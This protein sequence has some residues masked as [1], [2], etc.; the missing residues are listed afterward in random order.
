M[1]WDVFI[2][3]AWEDK[4]DIARPLAEALRREGLRVWYDE[5]TLTLGD[6]LRRSIDRGLAQSRYGVVILSSNFFAKEWPQ[7][8]LDGLAAREVHGE[9]VILPVWHNI[10]ADQVREYSP[11]LADRVAVLSDRGLEHVVEKLLRVIKPTELVRPIVLERVQLF[12]PEMVLIPAGEFLMGS[13]P[14]VDK[15]AWDNEQP[16]S[17]LYLLDYYLAKTPVTNAQ[18]AAFVQATDYRQ[19]KHWEDEEPPKGEEDHPVVWIT[20]YDAMAYCYWLAEATGKPYSLPSEAEWEKGARGSDGRI[21]PWGNQWDAERCNSK[22]GGKKDTTPVGAYPQGA[23]PYG[24]LDMAG[25]LWE[26]TRSIWKGYPYDPKDG[27]ED[28]ASKYYRVLRGGSFSN[29]ERFVR[30]SSRRWSYPDLFG[31]LIGLF[32]FRAVVLLAPLDSGGSNE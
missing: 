13:D 32:G 21:Y 7:K 3:H 26:W 16:Q 29:N 12:E 31:G 4:E 9:K 24:L 19:P 8:E 28:L 22:E 18:Y 2:S 30:C 1:D 17:T 25:N 20:W 10:T 5:F 6:S 15:D 14:S 11:T 23:S 27:R